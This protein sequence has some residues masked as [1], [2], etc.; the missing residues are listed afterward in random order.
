MYDESR[1]GR[2]YVGTT[3][4]IQNIAREKKRCIRTVYYI[5]TKN[6][7]SLRVGWLVTGFR[8]RSSRNS[9]NFTSIKFL[10]LK[11]RVCDSADVC[12]ANTAEPLFKHTI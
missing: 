12:G 11:R 6:N 9:E 2:P 3:A 1:S 7:R 10:A 8:V 4:C 5:Q